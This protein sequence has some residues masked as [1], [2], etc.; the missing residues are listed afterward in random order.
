MRRRSRGYRERGKVFVSLLRRC[1]VTRIFRDRVAGF[2]RRAGDIE[3]AGRR[4]RRR[5]QPRTL[6]PRPEPPPKT[7]LILASPV[8]AS[9]QNG[10]PRPI[11]KPPSSRQNQTFNVL[12]IPNHTFLYCSRRSLIA[13]DRWPCT[14]ATVCRAMTV[15]PCSSSL[16]VQTRTH[17]SDAMMR[18]S[19]H[20]NGTP[21]SVNCLIIFL[22]SEI[23]AV[24]SFC[25]FGAPGVLSVSAVDECLAAPLQLIFCHPARLRSGFD[26]STASCIDF[27]CPVIA[28][29]CAITLAVAFGFCRYVLNRSIAS[30]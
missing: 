5:R 25:R 22:A 21:R 15:L 19:L 27:I 20:P 4:N 23:A 9:Y 2:A 17:M 8:T 16:Q 18:A 30:T 10:A 3:G 13:R 12:G 28:C 7:L 29:D 26:A 11:R 6:Q 14:T 24:A 1:R